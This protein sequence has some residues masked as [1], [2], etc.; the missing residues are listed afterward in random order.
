[1]T[2]FY[3][4]FAYCNLHF[5]KDC[6]V[7]IQG[8]KYVFSGL[9]FFPEIYPNLKTLPFWLSLKFCFLVNFL[10]L[11]KISWFKMH[12][13]KL[14]PSHGGPDKVLSRHCDLLVNLSFCQRHLFCSSL[15]GTATTT[16]TATTD[17][18]LSSHGNPWLFLFYPTRWRDSNRNVFP[19]FSWACL[20][21]WIQ[22]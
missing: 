12:R 15:W 9:K 10:S 1:M 18:N 11:N 3:S 4:N 7:T 5:E 6:L 8:Q 20:G 21:F 22:V 13:M 16:A 2:D 19:S 17:L 14:V